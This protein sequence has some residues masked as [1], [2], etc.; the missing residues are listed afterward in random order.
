MG[1]MAVIGMGLT[2]CGGRAAN[3]TGGADPHR[4]SKL[5]VDHPISATKRREVELEALFGRV[6]ASFMAWMQALD[7]LRP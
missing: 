7:H 2:Y 4:S 3:R 6:L 5:R 1:M